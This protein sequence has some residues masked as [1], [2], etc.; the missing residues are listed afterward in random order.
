MLLASAAR[1]ALLLLLVLVLVVLLVGLGS[2]GVVVLLLV[3]VVVSCSVCCCCGASVTAGVPADSTCD[4]CQIH[5]QHTQSGGIL[6]AG[7]APSIA[8]GVVEVC[9]HLLEAEQER[10]WLP[11]SIAAAAAR[12]GW[13]FTPVLCC[14]ARQLHQ[15]AVVCQVAYM[16]LFWCWCGC[17]QIVDL[18]AQRALVCCWWVGTVQARQEEQRAVCVWPL[19]QYV[20]DVAGV[21]VK[22]VAMPQVVD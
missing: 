11:A 16:L 15:P 5:K 9:W 13:S 14:Y 12:G 7:I 1:V 22:S 8:V 3:V 17:W 6:S 10:T 4:V 18:H 2:V 19:S 21:D 20:A